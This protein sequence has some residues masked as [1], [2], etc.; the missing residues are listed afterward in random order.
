M[1]HT[2]RLPRPEVDL[3]PLCRAGEA[4]RLKANQSCLRSTSARADEPAP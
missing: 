4:G 3:H 2:E 1:D